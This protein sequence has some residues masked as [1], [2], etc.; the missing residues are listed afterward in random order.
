M[1]SAE[2]GAWPYGI[3][4]DGSH[5]WVYSNNERTLYEYDPVGDTVVDS[6]LLQD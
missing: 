5:H 3:A 4:W 6:V 1:T 2:M